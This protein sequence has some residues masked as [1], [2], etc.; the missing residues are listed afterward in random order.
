MC[1]KLLNFE[2]FISLSGARGGTGDSNSSL[3]NLQGYLHPGHVPQRKFHEDTGWETVT[4]ESNSHMR[5]RASS[6]LTPAKRMQHVS[7]VQVTV[8]SSRV[9]SSQLQTA[10]P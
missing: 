7:P 8:L 3:T 4:F 10:A 2:T 9:G 6:A 1:F 5:D